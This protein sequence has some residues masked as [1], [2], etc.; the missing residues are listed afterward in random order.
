MYQSTPEIV[1]IQNM[2]HRPNVAVVREAAEF[3]GSRHIHSLTNK[4]AATQRYIL[5]QIEVQ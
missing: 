1:P 2:Y 3:N 4:H 5:V